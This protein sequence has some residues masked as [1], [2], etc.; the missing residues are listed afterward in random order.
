MN[1]QKYNREIE[2]EINMKVKIINSIKVGEHIVEIPFNH[3]R[4]FTR[5]EEVEN[6]ILSN[7]IKYEILQDEDIKKQ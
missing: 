5:T 4:I 3:P 6:F 1:E 7:L 2:K